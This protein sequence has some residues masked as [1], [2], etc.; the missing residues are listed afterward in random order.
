M[1]ANN[2]QQPLDFT[3]SL[4]NQAMFHHAAGWF[5]HSQ[6]AGLHF[7]SLRD[8]GFPIPEHAER[9]IE[10]LGRVLSAPETESEPT[11]PQDPI[12]NNYY[13]QQVVAHLRA[14]LPH[15]SKGYRDF[16]KHYTVASPTAMADRGEAIKGLLYA[17]I[18]LAAE[19]G[20]IVTVE[21]RPF[22]DGR[23]A[24]GHAMT[25]IETRWDRPVYQHF[26]KL[27]DTEKVMLKPTEELNRELAQFEWDSR[28]AWQKENGGP[29]RETY[30][31][32]GWIVNGRE[33][34]TEDELTE[35]LRK[36]AIAVGIDLFKP[37]PPPNPHNVTREQVGVHSG[38]WEWP[39]AV[40]PPKPEVEEEPDPIIPLEVL[41]TIIALAERNTPIATR[42]ANA[43]LEKLGLSTRISM[44]PE[45]LDELS[46]IYDKPD[47]Q[48]QIQFGLMPA[49]NGSFT[50]ASLQQD[51]M[52][53]LRRLIKPSPVKITNGI[54][55]DSSPIAMGHPYAPYPARNW[56]VG[57]TFDSF[58]EEEGILGDCTA[59]AHR[60]VEG[61]NSYI[62]KV[63]DERGMPVTM[64]QDGSIEYYPV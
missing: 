21:R 24:M 34:R 8:Q 26:M 42:L 64:N 9:F 36:V 18:E 55:D 33:I 53:V 22:P 54:M 14:F 32:I 27:A 41:D 28:D 4:D 43:A 58:L 11:P 17:V 23:P 7:A 1:N 39:S 59:E 44:P 12:D 35:Y 50:Q 49:P 61:V 6:A 20:V 2:L 48:A 45:G 5:R 29:R 51:Q 40:I 38:A 13:A 57:S 15:A 19:E 56:H 62:E 47:A 60:L 63:K 25:A 3:E 16:G 10:P 30:M 52:P 31:E 37:V 46:S